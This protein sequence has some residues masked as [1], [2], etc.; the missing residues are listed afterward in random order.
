MPDLPVPVR[1]LK[2]FVEKREIVSEKEL[3]R[4]IGKDREYINVT[5]Q[6]FV[7]KELLIEEEGGYT[8]NPDS[9]HIYM[10]LEIYN[11]VIDKRVQK[12]LEDLSP[13]ISSELDMSH[14]HIV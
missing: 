11:H 13:D 2:Y 6:K 14:T 3:I 8:L 9:G 1:I 12:K 10:M 4:T 5:I 7:D